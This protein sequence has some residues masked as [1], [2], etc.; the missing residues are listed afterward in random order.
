MHI[1]RNYFFP[2][3]YSCLLAYS[4]GPTLYQRGETYPFCVF[5]GIVVILLS[6][7][8]YEK[9]EVHLLNHMLQF[10]SQNLVPRSIYF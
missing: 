10:P 7:I 2:C 6:S 1:Q 5:L 9:V 4:I 8:T 3:L